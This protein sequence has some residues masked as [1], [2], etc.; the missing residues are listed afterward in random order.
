MAAPDPK[1]PEL[2]HAKLERALNG[3]RVTSVKTESSCV[4]LFGPFVLPTFSVPLLMCG[5]WS[6]PHHTHTRTL[7]CSEQPD[8]VPGLLDMML[9]EELIPTGPVWE[10]QLRAVRRRAFTGG[11]IYDDETKRC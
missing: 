4:I 2:H 1:D 8:R 5:L 10:M 7:S 3:P 11:L 6:F 9:E